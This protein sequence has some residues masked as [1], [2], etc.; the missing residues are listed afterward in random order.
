MLAFILM[1][2]FFV[3]NAYYIPLICFRYLLLLCRES[4]LCPPGL[5]SESMLGLSSAFFGQS[6]T[7]IQ[8]TVVFLVAISLFSFR[9]LLRFCFV[10]FLLS[11]VV[12]LCV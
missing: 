6:K 3:E 7:D 11:N 12:A 2:L 1:H 4:R 9:L 8:V 10:C 5:V